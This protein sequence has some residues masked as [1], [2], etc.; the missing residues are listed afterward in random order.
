MS[1]GHARHT[2]RQ[3]EVLGLG[4]DLSRRA[5]SKCELCQETGPLRPI[6]LTPLPPEPTVEWAALLCERCQQAI[7]TKKINPKDDYQ[8]LRESIWSEIEPIQILAI[9][10]M[11]RLAEAGETWAQSSLDDLYIDPSIESRL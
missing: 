8:F 5:R 6:E 10:L 9:R 4:K 7:E 3:A 1:K 11:R 2:A